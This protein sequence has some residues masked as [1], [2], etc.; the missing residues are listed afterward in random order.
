M[1]IS[2]D[3]APLLSDFGIASLLTSSTFSMSVNGGMKGT[4][5]W[6]AAELLNQ[7]GT[8]PSKETDVWS[9]GMTVYVS[10]SP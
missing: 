3:G 9:F 7:A 8:V 10:A 5:R 1:L 6:M 4:A 2:A